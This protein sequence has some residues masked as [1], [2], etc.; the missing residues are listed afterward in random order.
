M[1]AV[2]NVSFVFQRQDNHGTEIDLDPRLKYVAPNEAPD[3][4]V[5]RIKIESAMVKLY[6]TRVA[7]RNQVQR[8]ISGG[9]PLSLIV[10]GDAFTAEFPLE[11]QD[12]A[13]RQSV[14]VVFG[15]LPFAPQTFGVNE[16]RRLRTFL[17]RVIGGKETK[18]EGELFRRSIDA[19]AKLR[20]YRPHRPI[21]RPIEE[22]LWYDNSAVQPGPEAAMGDTTA[23]PAAPQQDE[24]EGATAESQPK[25]SAGLA[26][27][28]TGKPDPDY[29]EVAPQQEETEQ[30]PAHSESNSAAQPSKTKASNPDRA[31]KAAASTGPSTPQAV[32]PASEI[33]P[34]GAV[35]D[36]VATANRS[37]G[38]HR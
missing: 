26:E 5:R 19:V 38:G 2:T 31:S 3:Q 29:R 24:E 6:G 35:L 36:E 21:F 8:F 22:P 33:E 11:L 9:D 13:N 12:D 18:A 4:L 10:D 25:E 16:M 23:K 37:S 34:G 15:Y 14:V 32:A 17:L 1:V 7:T 30:M 27:A 28:K 20:P